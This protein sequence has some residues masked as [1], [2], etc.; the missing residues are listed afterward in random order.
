MRRHL[1]GLALVSLLLARIGGTAD[2]QGAPSAD[3]YLC[4]DAALAPGRPRL[5]PGST[6]T[7]TDALGGSRT[8]DVTKVSTLC[9]PAS[10]NG[11]GI[12]HRA[13]H[14]EGFA[15]RAHPGNDPGWVSVKP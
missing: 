13:V 14:E 2:A 5:P 7:V 9:N 11:G 3:A 12:A 10:V 4:Y 6:A 15:D 1:T 8:L